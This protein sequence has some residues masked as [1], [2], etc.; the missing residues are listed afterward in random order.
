[1]CIDLKVRLLYTIFFRL[2]MGERQPPDQTG[3]SGSKGPPVKKRTITLK[4]DTEK[5]L[6]TSKAE[7]DW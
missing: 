2:I 1:M 4:S 5:F 6:V 7:I 3:P